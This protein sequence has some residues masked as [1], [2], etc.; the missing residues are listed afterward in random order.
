MPCELS[1]NLAR[2]DGIRYGLSEKGNDLL[3][4]YSKTRGLGFGE[5]IKRRIILGTFSLSHGY[6]DAYYKKAQSVRTLIIE[7]FKRAFKSCDV[8]LSPVAPTPAFKIGEKIEDPLKMYLSDIF[9]LS[10]N[11]A[12]IPG[13]SV[14]CGFSTQGLPIGLQIMGE[15]FNEEKMIKVAYNFEQA[16]DFHKKKPNL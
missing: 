10:A 9:T 14:P 8:L 15:H 16:T 13:M 2:Y 3:Q 7:D 11:L 12:G 1:S 6:Y 4:S 5:E